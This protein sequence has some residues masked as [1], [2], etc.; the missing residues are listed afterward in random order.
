MCQGVND[1]IFSS[2]IMMTVP[3]QLLICV[4]GLPVHC[5]W[6][7]SVRFWNH[8]GVKEWHGPIVHF[9]FYCT[10][11]SVLLF[12]QPSVSLV[13]HVDFSLQLSFHQVSFC[14]LLVLIFQLLY[15]FSLYFL[16][17]VLHVYPVWIVSSFQQIQCY[18]YF[19]HIS[20][21]FYSSFNSCR[22]NNSLL[23]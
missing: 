2:Q 4:S 16:S 11:Y 5:C 19:I 12:V 6:G 17:Q 23:I 20:P 21:L 13:F 1:T 15:I 7:E 10:L 8:Q 22:P 14:M 18:W 9:I 3:L